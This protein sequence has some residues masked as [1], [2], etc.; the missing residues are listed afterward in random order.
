M[1]WSMMRPV[2]V[3]AVLHLLIVG[4]AC[5]AE[6]AAATEV[7]PDE[8]DATAKVPNPASLLFG[9]RSRRSVCQK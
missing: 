6:S 5:T 1:A 2:A 9:F 3:A 7:Q 8:R 4:A